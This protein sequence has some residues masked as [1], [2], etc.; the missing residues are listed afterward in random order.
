METEN[1]QTRNVSTL[2]G[3]QQNWTDQSPV[4]KVQVVQNGIVKQD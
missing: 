1:L 4:T 2:N 3:V